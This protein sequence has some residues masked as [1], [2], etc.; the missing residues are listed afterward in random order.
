MPTQRRSSSNRLKKIVLGGGARE[1]STVTAMLDE[2]ARLRA[3]LGAQ[4]TDGCA[5]LRAGASCDCG[6]AQS[7]ARL[8]LEVN[9]LRATIVMGQQTITTHLVEIARLDGLL[10][11]ARRRRLP[12]MSKRLYTVRKV[13]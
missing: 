8:I 10:L 9:S 6:H 3:V 5:V 2:I 13:S 11:V 1:G 4:H 12:S 7:V